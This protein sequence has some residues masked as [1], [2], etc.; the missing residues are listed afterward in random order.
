[1]NA[2]TTLLHSLI[3]FVSIPK[4][5]PDGTSLGILKYSESTI[6]K[7]FGCVRIVLTTSSVVLEMYLT[8]IP[9]SSNNFFSGSD[10]MFT[11]VP[12]YRIVGVPEACIAGNPV[13]KP[14]P[15][16]APANAVVDLSMLLLV[17]FLFIFLDISTPL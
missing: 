9:V 8:L 2:V 11:A 4:R 7:L 3:L 13:I 15:R 17:I 10:P 1:M 14:E 12:K 5:L 6:S 16:A